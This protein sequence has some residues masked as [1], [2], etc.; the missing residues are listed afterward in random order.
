MEILSVAFLLHLFFGDEAQGRGVNA[1]AQPGGLWSVIKDM[2][3]GYRD[4][5][6]ESLGATR[7][8]AGYDQL[9][10]ALLEIGSSLD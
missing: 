5:S 10:P 3:F 6:A 1:V 4:R 8:L 9:L 2:T 7:L